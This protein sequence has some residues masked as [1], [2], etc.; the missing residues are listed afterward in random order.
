MP[1]IVTYPNELYIY[2]RGGDIFKNPDE[3]AYNYFQPPL[4][5]Y[6][7]ILDKFKYGKVFIISED[8]SNPVIRKLLSKYY[9]IK[10]MKNNIKSDISYLIYSYNLV[11]ARSTF[12]LTS[13]K[14][15]NKL[16]FLWEYDF[17]SLYQ[18]YLHLHYS[19]YN[20]P[21]YYTIYKMK[22]SNNYRKRMYPW[23]NSYSQRKMM[24]KEKCINNFEIIKGRNLSLT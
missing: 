14:F 20:F 13:I 24:I 5:F 2:I 22:S 4:C 16:K 8:K 6:I 3:T 12:F 7:K 11:A 23:I 19:V 15:N 10:I 1:T 21:C 17:L 18:K 9:Y